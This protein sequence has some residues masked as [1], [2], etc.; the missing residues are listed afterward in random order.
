MI[1]GYGSV[2]VQVVGIPAIV[3]S[4]AVDSYKSLPGEIMIAA[5]IVKNTFGVS[6]ILF[7]FWP[8]Q[9]RLT[10][11]YHSSVWF[12]SITTGLPSRGSSRLF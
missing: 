3:I 5:T 4:Y 2:G 11:G 7:S 1:V 6:A 9:S 8:S 10:A 12:S